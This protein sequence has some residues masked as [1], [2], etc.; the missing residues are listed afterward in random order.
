MNYI[1]Y[2][3]ILLLNFSC[4]PGDSPS[5]PP[6]NIYGCMD[7]ASCNYDPNVTVDNQTCWQPND[8]CICENGQGAS[9]DCN[10]ECGGSALYDNCGVCSGGSTGTIV[11]ECGVITD[12]CDLPINTIG[13]VPKKNDE[14]WGT[15]IYKTNTPIAGFQFNMYNLSYA[16]HPQL[17]LFYG[18]DADFEQFSIQSS[19]PGSPILGFNLIGNII[20]SQY[21]ENENYACGDLTNIA[22]ENDFNLHSD[23]IY[24]NSLVFSDHEG[25]NIDI[26]YHDT[27]PIEGYDCNGICAGLAYI[28]YC[29]VCVEGITNNE[30]C[31]GEYIDCFGNYGFESDPNVSEDCLGVCGGNAI[32]DC[33]GTCNGGSTIDCAG[34]CDGQSILDCAGVCNGPTV[35]D[36]AGVCGGTAYLDCAGSCNGNATID[37][38]GACNGNA[39]YDDCGV[40]GGDGTSC[41]LTACDLPINTLYL[42]NGAVLYNSSHNIAGFQFNVEGEGTTA[43]SVS[44]GDAVTAGFTVQTSGQTILGFS[45]TGST[46]QPGCGTLTNLTLTGDATGLSGIVVSDSNGGALDFTQYDDTSD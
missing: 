46:L 31:L 27:C 43:T 40:C 39:I 44:G 1:I 38:A 21:V 8:G 12:G 13:F 29:F 42:L 20:G 3:L 35:E 23:Q 14:E 4:E 16:P 45:F 33:A 19:A 22:Y 37:C 36:C 34:I 17:G 28:D 2:I 9:M 6:S 25:N 41:Q 10:N 7:A 30:D 32:H 15:I 11:N 24:M 5:G 18:G 26:S